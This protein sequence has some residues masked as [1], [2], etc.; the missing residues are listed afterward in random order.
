[1]A[2]RRS[3]T[4]EQLADAVA[5]SS[6]WRGVLRALGLVSASAGAMRA[7]RARADDLDIDYGHFKGQREWTEEDLRRAIAESGAWP[8]VAELLGIS[9]AA[10]AANVRGHAVRLGIDTSHLRMSDFITTVRE[11]G[12]DVSNLARAGSLL[13]AGW[14][15]LCG[16]DVSWP[17]EPSRYDLL[18]GDKRGVRRVQVKTTRTRAGASWK[19]YLSTSRGARRTYAPDEI[20]DFF[21]ID[22]DLN[23]YLI[24]VAAVGGLHA[25]HL[26]AYQS[27][28]AAPMV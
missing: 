18:V 14:F 4:D 8:R 9:G 17:L 13:A 27:Y 24:P 3:Y 22:G 6:S 1:M 25:I 5:K 10:S 2:R 20:D 26:A 12:P 23:Y 21:V 28:L 19:V 16:R 7:A 11:P 15:A